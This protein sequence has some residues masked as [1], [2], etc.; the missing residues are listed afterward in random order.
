MRLKPAMSSKFW[1]YVH[2]AAYS[3]RLTVGSINQTS[4]IQ[5]SDQSRYFDELAPFPPLSEQ[6]AIA[7]FLDRETAKIDALVEAQRRLIELLKEKRQAVIFHAVTKGLDP[8]APMK[9][10]GRRMARPGAS[11]LGGGSA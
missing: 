1:C 10:S 8:S 2:A 6:D 11:A 5:N 3:I 9:D 7:A 4:G